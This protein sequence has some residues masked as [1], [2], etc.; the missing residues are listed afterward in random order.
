MCVV[1]TMRKRQMEDE[2]NKAL[3]G[4]QEEY[5]GST[6]ADVRSHIVRDIV[7]IRLCG[8]LSPSEV[9]LAHNE[10]GCQLVKHSR[11][12]LLENLRGVL[13]D[14]VRSITGCSPASLHMDVSTRT[15]EMLLAI[16]LPEDL[17]QK[18]SAEN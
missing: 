15:G 12:R 10:A 13:G 5:M 3:I 14:I 1:Q 6:P 11:S 9:N 18:L 8:V 17:E 16:T 7:V 2:L 4:F